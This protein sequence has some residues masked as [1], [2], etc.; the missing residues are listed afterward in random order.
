M[1][2]AARE[3]MLHPWFG[4]VIHADGDQQQTAGL[5]IHEPEHWL[6]AAKDDILFYIS[7][8]FL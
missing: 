2:L 6:L 4:L 7:L 8:I 3:S 5:P 1:H